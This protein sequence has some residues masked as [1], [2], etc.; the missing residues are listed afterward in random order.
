MFELLGLIFLGTAWLVPNHYPPWSSFYNDSCAAV[1]LLLL[2]VGLRHRLRLQAP[3]LVAWVALAVAAIPVI[4]WSAGLL[5]FSGDVIVSTL[6]LVGIALAVATGYAWASADAGTASARLAATT[7]AAAGVSATLAIIQGLQVAGLG[8]WML[9][10]LPGMRPYANLG[11]PNNLAT[12]IGWGAVAVFLLREQRRLSGGAC[13]ALL[14]VLVFAAGMTQSRT[15]LLFGPVVLLVLLFSRRRGIAVRTSPAAVLGLMAIHWALTLSWPLLR[16][17][18]GLAAPGGLETRGLGSLRLEVW[19]ILFDALSEAPWRGYGW[20][21]VGAAQLA[22][23]G[24]HPPVGEL[25]LQGHN[26]FVDLLV[27]CGYPLGL[28]L[29]AAIVWWYASRLMRVRT[30]EGLTGMLAATVL[31]VH[32]M[33]ELPHHYAYFLIPVGLWIGI[34]ERT[35]GAAPVLTPRWTLAPAALALLMLVA[36]WRDYPQVE[37]DFRLVRFEGLRIGSVRADRPSPEAPYL[38]SLTGFLRFARTTA[39]PGMSTSQ[40][41]DMAAVVNRY[42]YAA[43]MARYARALA[44]N[45]RVDEGRRLFAEI[46]RI[47]GSKFYRSLRQDLAE[48][49]EQGETGLQPLAQSLPE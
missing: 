27:W 23:A 32:A 26:L 24:R 5:A 10:P 44:L 15:A 40:L 48:R 14:A 11:Q 9:D 7:L 37:E 31:G 2:M 8:I 33:L 17:A 21:Q 38:S 30:L 35:T 12:L 28:G 25:W 1:G 22:A 46:E 19:P 43:S 18:L 13:V 34:V 6:Y 16:A 49:I 41:G 39:A 4:Q 47:H 20:L 36:V 29:C 42:P 45:G 3:P